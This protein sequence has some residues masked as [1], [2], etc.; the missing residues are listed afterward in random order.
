MYTILH[1]GCIL[2]LLLLLKESDFNIQSLMYNLDSYFSGLL[3]AM[4][5]LIV[6]M[7]RS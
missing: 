3:L 2:L 4:I 7:K 6:K 5:K 1:S